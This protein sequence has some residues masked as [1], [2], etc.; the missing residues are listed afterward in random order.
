MAR[1]E[2]RVNDLF[3]TGAE[4]DEVWP[5]VRDFHYS[6]RLPANIQHCYC[7]REGGGLF[8]DF[9]PIRAA[10]VFTI[11][12]T[13]WK[14]EVI[15]LARLVRD[16]TFR[17]P[18]SR[19]IAFACTRLRLNGWALAVSFADATQGHHGGIYQAAGWNYDGQRERAMDGLMIDGEFKPGRSC[20]STWGTRSPE[21]LRALLP[22]R[23]IAPHFDAGKHLYWKALTVGGRTK[24]RRMGLKSLSYPKPAASPSDE[25]VPTHVSDVQPV[26]AAPN[27]SPKPKQAE[28]L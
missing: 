25:C 12:P 28:L 20:N 17:E 23:I 18:L 2:V 26:V 15:E 3:Y 1:E 19:L 22:R 10:I 27:P 4:S 13:R 16:P 7:A 24:A 8:G 11:P 9:G 21:K 5:L 14:E 6:R